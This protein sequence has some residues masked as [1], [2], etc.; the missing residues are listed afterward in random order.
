MSALLHP[1]ILTSVQQSH[2][3]EKC[4][5]TATC[6]ETEAFH[7]FVLAVCNTPRDPD[8]GQLENIF[9]SASTS[10]HSANSAT[11]AVSH[12]IASQA[13]LTFERIAFASS[14]P[15]SNLP[16]QYNLFGNH[17]RND[18]PNS[19][20]RTRPRKPCPWT[21]DILDLSTPELNHFIKTH[22]LTAQQRAHLKECRRRKLNRR[23]A[24]VSRG[25]RIN[26]EL[27]PQQGGRRRSADGSLAPLKRDATEQQI[28]SEYQRELE[29]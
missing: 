26:G 21:D 3:D 8:L 10:A 13:R 9:D 29:E 28:Y 19:L 12:Q 7:H 17:V 25:R 11:S 22:N 27:K 23:Y 4:V 6:D 15:D 5:A 20:K 2:L 16:F 24:T 14:V 1:T 18:L